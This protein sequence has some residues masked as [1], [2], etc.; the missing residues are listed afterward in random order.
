MR[1]AALLARRL[2]GSPYAHQAGHTLTAGGNY[3][4]TYVGANLTIKSWNAQ[5]YGFYSPV[6]DSGFVA[7]TGP[8][9]VLPTA[10]SGTLWNS[11][12]GGSTVPLKFNVFAGTV[13]KTSLSDIAGFTPDAAAQ[14]RGW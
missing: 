10:N 5:G 7:S 11:V 1:S 2:A 9:P 8:N 14:L 4:L 13:E 12:K 6:D 3:N